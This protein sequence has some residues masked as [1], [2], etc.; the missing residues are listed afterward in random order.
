VALQP[1]PSPN[2]WRWPDTY[3]RENRAQDSAGA[4]WAALGEVTDWSGA[5]VLDVGC[6]DGFHL[7]LFARTARGV[8]G[9]EPYPPLVARARR[10]VAEL[11]GVRV[12]PGGAQ[13]L[14]LPDASIDLV[15]A[16]TAYFFG[17]G[18]EP[19]LSEADRVLRPGGVLAI[20]DLDATHPPYGDWMRGDLPQY[21]PAAVEQFF[22]RHGFALHRVP[23]EWHFAD[24][25]SLEAV[26]RIEFSAQVAR[27]AIAATEG[28][29]V[30]VGYRLH[31]RRKPTG[32]VRAGSAQL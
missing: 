10:R 1:V 3:E 30:P 19:G 14:P 12:L 13:D 8:V 20:V 6:G 18:C 9:V 32:L 22:D 29:T 7:P 27:R 25:E 23:T 16:R 11:P 24:R 17:P 31:T 21:D 15:H 28:L 2:I 5:D 26:L 4:I